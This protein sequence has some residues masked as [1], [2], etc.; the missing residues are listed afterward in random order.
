MNTKEIIMR[1][2]NY[3]HDASVGSISYMIDPLGSR[4]L[5]ID[6]RYHSECGDANL[7]GKHIKIKYTNILLITG[8]IY[9]YISG[10]EALESIQ[11]TISESTTH[12]ISKL[13][14]L[15]I[16]QPNVLHTLVLQSGSEL[17]IA[18][19]SVNIETV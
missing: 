11:Q 19:Q 2:I 14:Q 8:N 6:L 1:D 7:S 12:R 5:I 4:D 15:G 9:G 16:S 3:L 10:A 17:E 13:V 18:C